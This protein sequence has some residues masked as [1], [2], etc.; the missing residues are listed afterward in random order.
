VGTVLLTCPRPIP[1]RHYISCHSCILRS[2]NPDCVRDALHGG[3]T[4]W[5]IKVL[6]RGNP[7]PAQRAQALRGPCRRRAGASCAA[8][9]TPPVG[10]TR[11]RRTLTGSGTRRERGR[12]ATPLRV[13]LHQDWVGLHVH[14]GDRDNVNLEFRVRTSPSS[15]KAATGGDEDQNLA[16]YKDGLVGKTVQLAQ[17]CLRRLWRRKTLV[18]K[19]N[20]GDHKRHIPAGVHAVACRRNRVNPV[21]GTV[22]RWFLLRIVC[23]RWI[24]R[25]HVRRDVGRGS[26]FANHVSQPRKELDLAG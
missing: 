23:R 21:L 12:T 9:R 25:L 10:T 4:K 15:Y 22:C 3:T 14:I 24:A 6:R 11:A 5:K 19:W 13:H 2:Y 18:I 20:G 1:P 8:C 7:S 17:M 26:P 16:G